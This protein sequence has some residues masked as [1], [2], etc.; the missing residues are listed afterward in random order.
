MTAEQ[1]RLIRTSFAAAAPQRARLAPVFFDALFEREPSL[2]AILGGGTPPLAASLF[3]GLSEIVASLDRLH[4]IL[5]ALEW[6]AERSA[7]RGIG[8][9]RYA[10]FE[11]A[12]LAALETALGEDFTPATREAWSA[13]CRRVG[14]AMAMAVAAEP[15]AA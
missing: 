3:R 4:P 15:L 13:A 6:L 5:P 12:L 9:A 2:R 14:G 7:W 8:P 1:I 11:T 10:A